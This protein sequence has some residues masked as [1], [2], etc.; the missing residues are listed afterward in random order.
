[1]D[2]LTCFPVRADYILCWGYEIMYI[3]YELFP[4]FLP[5]SLGREAARSCNWCCL[6]SSEPF[7]AAKIVPTTLH[8]VSCAMELSALF[9][10]GTSQG[11][12]TK[13]LSSSLLLRA[14]RIISP[15]GYRYPVQFSCALI[16]IACR[17]DLVSSGCMTTGRRSVGSLSSDRPQPE[18]R[19]AVFS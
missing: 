10:P 17:T 13:S 11:E 2:A 6:F 18:R 5:L 12:C 1:M 3:M 9:Q 4:G 19:S 15:K 14:E 7:C 8:T 16:Q